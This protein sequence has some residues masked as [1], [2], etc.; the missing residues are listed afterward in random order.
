M[1]RLS[2]II[3]AFAVAV[4]LWGAKHLHFDGIPIDGTIA[5]FTEKMKAVG[6]RVHPSSKKMPAGMRYFISPDTPDNDYLEYYSLCVKYDVRTKTVFCVSQVYEFKNT[7]GGLAT[8]K[9]LFDETK[10]RLSATYLDSDSCGSGVMEAAD[11][12]PFYGVD[13]NNADCEFIGTISCRIDCDSSLLPDRILL[14]IEYS[15]VLNS[16]KYFR[17]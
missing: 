15:D 8:S 3:I 7:I 17:P 9:R 11:G 5:S 6:Y 10:A 1:K 2:L 12:L 4:T 13:V 14:F 16:R